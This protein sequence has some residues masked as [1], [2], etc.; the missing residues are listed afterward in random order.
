[1]NIV[2]TTKT[3]SGNALTRQ[4]KRASQ[5]ILKARLNNARKILLISAFGTGFTKILAQD[6][7]K[8]LPIFAGA[9]IGAIIGHYTI[10]N[11][12]RE[13]TRDAL[14]ELKTLEASNEYKQI[15]ERA[16]SIKNAQKTIG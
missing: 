7:A 2:S 1:M 10:G 3:Y 14:R 12:G 4:V 5:D 6:A 15:V 16:K 9:T 13:A 11:A 8:I